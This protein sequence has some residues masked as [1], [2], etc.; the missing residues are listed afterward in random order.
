M[1]AE[2]TLHVLIETHPGSLSEER[3]I[4]M[5]APDYL[6]DFSDKDWTAFVKGL[7]QGHKLET[8]IDPIGVTIYDNEEQV[9]K[10]F[11]I[12]IQPVLDI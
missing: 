12:A 9:D 7:I 1:T 6:E 3:V 4:T 2:K 11:E 8:I 5:T 10:L